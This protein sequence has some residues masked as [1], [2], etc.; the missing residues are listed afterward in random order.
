[1]FVVYNGPY[2]YFQDP[3]LNLISLNLSKDSKTAY[4]SAVLNSQAQQLTLRF[5]NFSFSLQK[6]E[7]A[8]RYKPRRRSTDPN[9]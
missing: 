2:V 1:M 7:P 8:K 6:V 3:K 9:I 4:A 5:S